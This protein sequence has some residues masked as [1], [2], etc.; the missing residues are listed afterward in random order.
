MLSEVVTFLF[1]KSKVEFKIYPSNTAACKH[2]SKCDVDNKRRKLVSFCRQGY[3]FD[4]WKIWKF[5]Q[6]WVLFSI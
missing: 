4:F 6:A 2:K 3:F 5:V 1:Q